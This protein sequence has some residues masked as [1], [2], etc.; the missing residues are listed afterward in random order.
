VDRGEGGSGQ[1]GRPSIQHSVNNRKISNFFDNFSEKNRKKFEKSPKNSA[2][3]HAFVFGHFRQKFSGFFGFFRKKRKFFSKRPKT[4]AWV[5]GEFFR[6][7]FRIFR[8]FSVFSEKL[9][10]KSE[11]FR[12]FSVIHC[13]A[14]VLK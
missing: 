7:F 13:N 10:K 8:N 1:S 14:S 2:P 12:F 11:N 5:G 4:K 6:R 3:T 9:S